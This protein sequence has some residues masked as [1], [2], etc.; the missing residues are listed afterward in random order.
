LEGL[1]ERRDRDTIIQYLRTGGVGMDPS[2]TSWCAAFVNSSL[3]REGIRGSGSAVATSF[4][5][6][7]M[8]VSGGPEKGDVLVQPRGHRAGETGGH[9]G[10]ATGRVRQGPAGTEYEM[11][12]GNTKDSVLRYWI[13]AS[14][15]T[16]RRALPNVGTGAAPAASGADSDRPVI[17]RSESSTHVNQVIVNTHATNASGIADD[18]KSAIGKQLAPV[19]E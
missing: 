17:N 14:Q 13:A 6:W 5:K 8:G 19:E 15:V 3:Q 11:I 9:V 12:A 2:T 7:G 1:H 10:F 4:L 18:V 16:V